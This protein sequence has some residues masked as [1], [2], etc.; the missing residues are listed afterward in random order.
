MTTTTEIHAACLVAIRA[1]SSTGNRF[2]VE[3]AEDL[4]DRALR[5]VAAGNIKAAAEFAAQACGVLGV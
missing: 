1:K 3:Q 5:C 4:V 2:L